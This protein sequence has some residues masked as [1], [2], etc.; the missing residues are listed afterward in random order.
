MWKGREGATFKE[1]LSVEGCKG[2]SE[3]VLKK[4]RLVM[5]VERKRL[6]KYRRQLGGGMW[7]ERLKKG[8]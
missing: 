8:R 1:R 7:K 5:G 3:K 6:G 2:G 4:G